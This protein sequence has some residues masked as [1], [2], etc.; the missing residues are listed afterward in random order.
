[1]KRK[2]N[3]EPRVLYRACAK[4]GCPG[5]TT[6]IYCEKHDEAKS[7]VKRRKSSE[8]QSLYK[9]K[10]YLKRRQVFLSLNPWCTRCGTVATELDHIVPHKG[11]TTRFFDEKN[12]Q[13]LCKRCHDNKTSSEDG[14]FGNPRGDRKS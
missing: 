13:G 2:V 9:T 3:T 5:I 4:P 1:M 11:S 7:Q 10:R 14:G 12:W 6:G 8:Y